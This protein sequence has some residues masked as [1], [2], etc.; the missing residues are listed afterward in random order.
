MKYVHVKEQTIL[1]KKQKQL[2][3]RP[4]MGEEELSF[5]YQKTQQSTKSYH[6]RCCYFQTRKLIYFL[7]A[8]KSSGA[9]P[10]PQV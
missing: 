7:P 1:S 9:Y 8:N 5:I 4:Q 6:S 10:T 3:I 2:N